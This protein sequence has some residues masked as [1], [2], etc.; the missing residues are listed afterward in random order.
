MSRIF[1]SIARIALVALALVPSVLAQSQATTGV[2]EGT[3]LD[4]SGAPVPGAS[5]TI[6]NTA[7]NF[8]RVLH[9]D[10]RGGFRGLLLP[11]RPHRATVPM[12]GFTTLTRDG[13]HLAL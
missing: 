5:V 11:L 2:I 10:S 3:V 4:A 9:T 6:R 1:R 12:P 8:Q 7:P 13:I